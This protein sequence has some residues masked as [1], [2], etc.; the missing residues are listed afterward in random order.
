MNGGHRVAARGH[1]ARSS[2][3]ER[4][5]SDNTRRTTLHLPIARRAW[6]LSELS[7]SMNTVLSGGLRRVGSGSYCEVRIGAH[8]SV[9]AGKKRVCEGSE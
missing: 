5:V 2:P 8:P 7:Q 6:T 9:G 4:G 3:R 1:P